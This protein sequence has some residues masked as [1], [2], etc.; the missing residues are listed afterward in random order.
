MELEQIYQMYGLPSYSMDD[1][2]D[3]VQFYEIENGKAF[4]EITGQSE[5]IPKVMIGF[6][7]EYYW[8]PDKSLVQTRHRCTVLPGKCLYFATQPSDLTKHEKT[9]TDQTK[10]K[11]KQVS[12][13]HMTHIIWS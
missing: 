7:S 9:C 11:T 1:A 10:V 12:L 2:P 3:C 4:I 6:D 5:I 8:I 13:Y